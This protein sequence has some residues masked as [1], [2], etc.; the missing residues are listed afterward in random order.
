MGVPDVP[1][2]PVLLSLMRVLRFVAD[3]SEH[4]VVVVYDGVERVFGVTG[5]RASARRSSS[6]RPSRLRDG[7]FEGAVWP[8]GDELNHFVLNPAHG[9]F[10]DSDGLWEPALPT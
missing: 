1:A 9:V 6:R 4:A 3:H 10:T 5:D 7:P 2:R 8:T